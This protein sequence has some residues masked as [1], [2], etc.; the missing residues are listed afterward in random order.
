[1]G[2]YNRKDPSIVKR[3]H[4]PE[5]PL[6]LL[7]GT[8]AMFLANEILRERGAEDEKHRALSA[9]TDFEGLGDFADTPV[10]KM[11][12]SMRR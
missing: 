11:L 2:A 12:L 10:A 7:L 5:P 6:R 8:D 1:V 3:A 4:M 9:S